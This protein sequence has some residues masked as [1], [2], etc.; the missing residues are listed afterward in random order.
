MKLNSAS[1][2]NASYTNTSVFLE[3]SP[4]G[5]SLYYKEPALQKTIPVFERHLLIDIKIL[6]K[7]SVIYYSST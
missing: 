6:S 3:H 1:D 2:N 7:I 4:S 5:G